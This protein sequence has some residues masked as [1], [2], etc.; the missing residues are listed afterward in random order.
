MKV[1]IF[2]LL[3]V[4]TALV[5]SLQA[6]AQQVRQTLHRHVR[7]AVSEG[8]AALVGPLPAAQHLNL[9]I[10]L[11]L[12]NTSELAS[13]LSRI[14]DPSSPDYHHFLSVDQFAEQFGPS[15]EDYQAVVDFAKGSGFRVTGAPANRMLVPITGTAAQVEK[16][17]NVTMNVYRHPT[18]ERDFFS[19]NRE[20][21]LTLRV[22]VAHIAGLNN[23]SIPRPAAKRASAVQVPATSTGSGPSG[24]YLG[25]DM[26]AAYYG[27]T[28]LTGSGQ[29]VGLAE[30]DGYYLNDV[31]LNFSNVGQSYNVPIENVLLDGAT[32][33]PASGE[34]VEE[35]LDIV[36]AISMAPGLKQVRVYIGSN[37]A[38][39]FNAMASEN[40]AKQLSVSWT[41]N[42]DDPVTDDIFF[43]E[44]AAQGQSVF[45][46][47]GDYGSFDPYISYDSYP[48]EDAWV[49]AVGGTSLLTNGAGGA[50]SSESGWSYSGGGISAYG[51]SIPSW[52][53]GVADSSNGASSTL[54]NVPDVAA[55][56]DFDNYVCHMGECEGGWGGTSFAAPRWAA[57]MALTNQQAVSATNVTVGFINPAVYAIAEGS[58]YLSDFHDITSGQNGDFSAVQGYDLVTGWGSPTGQGLIDALA[59]A[60]SLGFQLSA[61]PSSLTIAP[62]ASGTTT[63]SV[64]D[65]AGFSGSVNFSI[66]GLP[67]GVTASFAPNPNSGSSVLT[68]TVSNSAVRGSYL[69]TITGTAGTK[70]AN[71]SLA[72]L[73]NAPGFSILPSPSSR[74]YIR[75]GSS[76]STT[77]VITDYA[78]F[79]D[80]VSLAVTSALPAGVTASWIPNPT[81]NSSVLT[82]TADQSA[83]SSPTMV[84][85]TGT[86][87]TLSATTDVALNM[88]PNYCFQL[89]IS[90]IPFALV[91]GTS[92]T[93]PI[94]IAPG[95]EGSFTGSVTLSAPQLPTGVT[96]S[97][98]PNPAVGSSLMTLTTSSTA[99]LG[100]FWGDVAGSAAGCGETQ[101]LFTPTITATPVP[102][103]TVGSS[104]AALYLTRGSS[105]TATIT[106][107]PL[108]G[109]VGSV[110][111]A[112][113]QL[114]VGVTASF[115]PNS[116]T[117][118]SSVMTLTASNSAAVGPWGLQV[119]GISSK[120]SVVPVEMALTVNPLPAFTISASPTSLTV[121]QGSSSTSTITV[122]PQ[123]GFTGSV[124]LSAP[125]LP[126]GL[127][128]SFAP[129]PT[130][131]SSVLTLSANYPI[132]AGSYL[133]TIAGTSGVQ[134]ATAPVT[135]SVTPG[136]AMSTTTVLTINPSSGTLTAGSSYTLTA[137][138]TPGS[139]ST[140]P[141]GNVVFNI[142][143][144]TQTA[145]LNSSGV[146]TYTGAAPAA[147]GT[148]TLSA[149]YQ[150]TA[151]FLT[152]TSNLLTETIAPKPSFTLSG[153]PVTIAPGATTGNSSTITVVPTGGFTGSVAL[154]ATITS[155][156]AG[157]QYPP[158]LSFGSTSPVNITSGSVAATL[159][160]STTAATTNA[161]LHPVG[162]RGLW[163]STG[164]G[165]I[166]CILI[167]GIPARQRKRRTKLGLL[168]LLVTLAGALA[169]CGGGSGS[170]GTTGIPGTTPGSYVAT[171]TGT[172]G[173][174]TATC[175]VTITVQ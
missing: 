80:S 113:P 121:V 123:S 97:F 143:S 160:V 92:T 53:A 8:R 175:T 35:V 41:W 27:G 140:V 52:Q 168:L 133:G 15:A 149:T 120:G 74:L 146:A 44:F 111:L 128:A 118:G 141:A 4:G 170:G 50:W 34:D 132:N 138:V 102:T 154:T 3:L 159:T 94:T 26:R 85:V 173:A 164:G 101:F 36:Q 134:T 73:V 78:G 6:Q 21:V 127:S 66:S 91:Q 83:N 67:N 40:L 9:S 25:S 150:G 22:P 142:G 76:T 105:T 16:A 51:I 71:S 110:I 59:P 147:T 163:Y 48:A 139:G 157:A 145:A 86:S 28:A 84:T 17:F 95:S 129:N 124:S 161:L 117:G 23:F 2:W 1:R 69:V 112:A 155:G 49:T 122:T 32:G 42:P 24:S 144:A 62:G 65:V 46:A 64:S 30:F 106:V 125:N 165:A 131:G 153:T 55:E 79:S 12:R 116:T 39:V 7:P 70:T 81:T 169:S 167:F 11:P 114:P 98:S 88:L 171:V 136:V 93:A 14:Y 43:Q 172:S 108:N 47:S 31:N 63:I 29:T 107:T 166:A 130:T 37:D 89:Y 126:S 135:L 137:T 45:V 60:A 33:T 151:E 61:S 58:N 20:P 13:L 115:S 174:N 162:L 156:P 77:I 104:T 72:L 54:R 103:F 82:L 99:P 56:A 96:A 18:E 10:V 57:F 90:P 68:L 87:G 148:L 119:A 38:D 19:P 109:F 75:P 158:T 152:S 5:F 100:T